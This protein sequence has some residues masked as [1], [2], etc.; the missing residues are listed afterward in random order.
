MLRLC[1]QSRVRYFINELPDSLDETYERVLK[2]V[3]KTNQ[4]HVQ[5]FLQ[6]LAVAI[7]PLRVDELAV[8]LTFD[9]DAIQGEVPTL[10]ADRR[11][12]D[13]EQDVLS[14]CPSLITIVNSHGSRV[15]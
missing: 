13:Q 9:P 14:A 4:S 10:D 15:V 12:E 7:R 2:G 8:I 6:G 3:H 1:L 11:S 5:R